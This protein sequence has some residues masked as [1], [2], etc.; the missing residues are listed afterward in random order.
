MQWGEIIAPERQEPEE[1]RTDLDLRVFG[2][3]P[4]PPLALVTRKDCLEALSQRVRIGLQH[5]REIALSD[6]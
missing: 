2:I 1:I 5:I 3:D 4:A 6:G